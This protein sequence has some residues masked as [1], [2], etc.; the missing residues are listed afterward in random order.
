METGIPEDELLLKIVIV[1]DSGVGKSN[2]LSRYIHNYFNEDI[3]STLGVDLLSKRMKIENMNVN[4][5][6]WDT[7][8]QER[9]RSLTN[10]Y[11]RNAN[12]IIVVFDISVKE[13]FR[14]LNYWIKEVKRNSSENVKIIIVGNKTDLTS[15]RQVSQEEARGFADSRGYFYMEFSAKMNY[16]NK[17][18]QCME[19]LARDIVHG[20]MPNQIDELKTEGKLRKNNYENAQRLR[21]EEKGAKQKCC[22]YI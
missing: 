17:V 12:G 4:V 20:L 2:I 22:Q 8:G 18:H 10:A 6:F 3:T 7:A 5:Q 21:T 13:S 9:L 19:T 14:N 1:G 11:Y 15:Q 16:E